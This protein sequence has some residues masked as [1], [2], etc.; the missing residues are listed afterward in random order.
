MLRGILPD[1]MKREEYDMSKKGIESLMA[2]LAR[3]HPEDYAKISHK[4][5]TL[6]RDASF[7]QGNTVAHN[8][9]KPVLRVTDYTDM[10]DAEIADLRKQGLPKAEFEDMRN[11][12]YVRYADILEKDTV[13]KA[14]SAGNNWAK[15]VVSG[16]RGKGQHLKSILSTPGV[17]ADATGKVI[18]L[19]VR[20]GYAQGVRPAELL[21]G[22]YGGRSAVVST[23]VAT[24]KGGDFGKILVQSSAGTVVTSKDCGVDNG[25]DFDS[26]DKSLRGR[27]LVREAAGYPAGTVIDKFVQAKLKKVKAP[28]IARSA[29]TCTSRH[30]VCAKCA[31]LSPEGKFHNIG[32]SIGIS[33]AQS[34]SEP[35]TQMALNAK[36]T[37]G[38]ASGKKE[39]SG[40][41]YISQFVQV[42]EN[43]QD[44]AAVT[45]EDGIVE[46]VDKAPQGGHYVTVAGSQYYVPTGMNPTVKV[47][48]EV[49]AG[50]A[51]SDGLVS[52]ADVVR[53]QGLGRGR[54]YYTD[55]LEKLLGDSGVGADRRQIE[56]VARGTVNHVRINA[57]DDDSDF[58]PDDL[59]TNEA[60]MEH[61]KTPGNTKTT[62]LH[63]AKGQYMQKP[64]LHYTVGTRVTPK[65]VARLQKAAIEE[66]DVSPD[67]PKNSAEMQRLRT[68]SHNNK[69]WMASMSTSYLKKQLVESAAAGHDTNVQSNIHYAPRLAVGAGFGD[70]ASKDG[71][72]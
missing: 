54:R 30:G 21:A 14:I 26:D 40:F 43:F 22:T 32:D 56:L 28:I 6:G 16:A 25:L 33:A 58:I 52:P 68:A 60:I 55:R 66:I 36:H 67:K 72:F 59:V 37:G 20:N 71:M 23:K 8:D 49:E 41:N 11:A 42:P 15:H 24:A 19:F 10:M 50:S 46:A 34:V 29:L 44:G 12:I 64:M 5:G 2:E 51:L 27:V 39:F 47:G 35:I 4:I 53:L 65:V 62:N 63:Q 1:D 31:G 7:Y 48:E 9:M 13:N 69:D 17:F 61:Y 70:T 45:E 38:A 18:P 57:V 3:S